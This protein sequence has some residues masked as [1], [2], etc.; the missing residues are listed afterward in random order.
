MKNKPWKNAQTAIELTSLLDV[1]FIVLMIVVCNQQIT[2]K[3]ELDSARMQVES[4]RE[5]EADYEQKMQGIAEKQEKADQLLKEAEKM[6][7]EEDAVVREKDFYAEQLNTYSDIQNQILPVTIYVDYAPSDIKNRTIRVL[8][9]SEEM[10]PISVNPENMQEAFL[11]ME[12]ALAAVLEE[13][14]QTPVIAA[15]SKSQILY[16]D[17]K[18]VSEVLEHLGSRFTN[19]YRKAGGAGEDE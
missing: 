9:G 15:V 18:A 5:A 14:A 16:R 19:L 8:K 10:P 4:A 6:K 2:T 11:K 12:T 17:E 13:N 7:A 3:A 1:I